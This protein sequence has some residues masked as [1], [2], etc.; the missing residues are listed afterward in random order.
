MGLLG[1]PSISITRPSLTYTFRLHP[2]AQYGQTLCTAFASR[3][4][5]AFSRLSL[6]NGCTLEP[7]SIASDTSDSAGWG[8]IGSN[9][10]SCI[11]TILFQENI[12]IQVLR[13]DAVDSFS[14]IAMIGLYR[15]CTTF[16]AE[17]PYQGNERTRVP[18]RDACAARYCFILI[19]VRRCRITA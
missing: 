7:I 18:G 12:N 9:L 19:L 5:G 2:T 14:I 15:Y 13:M 11:N 4:R 16:R 10:R 8:S 6:L 1:S 17:Q 3:M